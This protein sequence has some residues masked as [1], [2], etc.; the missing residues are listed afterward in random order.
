VPKHRAALAVG[1]LLLAAVLV[2]ALP[3]AT[4][5]A[6]SGGAAPPSVLDPAPVPGT[7]AKLL[8]NGLAAAPA[9]A[10]VEVQRAIAAGNAI[11]KAGYCSGGGHAQFRSP[12]YDCSGA[13]SYL[14]GPKGAGI[15]DSPLP[16][17]DFSKWGEPGKG[18]WITVYYNRGH[19]FIA[20]AGLRFDTSTPDDGDAGPGWGKRIR[21]GMVNGPFR[22]RYFPGL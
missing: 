7:K 15:L 6:G 20:V 13:V 19:T 22:K 3:A 11:N 18:G 21:D 9:G 12:C 14:L 16:S 8:P 4:A 2:I 10:P 17:Y 5:S 1:G